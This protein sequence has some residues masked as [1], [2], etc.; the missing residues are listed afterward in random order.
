MYTKSPIIRDYC[1]ADH[2]TYLN[3]CLQC[4][5]I[6]KAKS[7]FKLYFSSYIHAFNVPRNDL[8][9]DFINYYQSHLRNIGTRSRCRLTCSNR[10]KTRCALRLLFS[11]KPQIKIGDDCLE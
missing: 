11:S 7:N 4:L 2:L 8:S 6:L 3:A 5:F 10:W 1:I 9:C